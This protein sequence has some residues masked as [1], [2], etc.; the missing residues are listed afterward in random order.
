MAKLPTS[1]PPLGDGATNAD[2]MSEARTHA[3]LD[4]GSRRRRAMEVPGRLIGVRER[5]GLERD[6]CGD[7][8]GRRADMRRKNGL[9][10]VGGRT[11]NGYGSV[12][13]F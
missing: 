5:A 8:G 13:F 3:P 6:G 4:V 2:A 9:E 11:R 10:V 7:D 12:N 1:D